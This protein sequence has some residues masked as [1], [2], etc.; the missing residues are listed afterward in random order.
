MVS[1]WWFIAAY[2]CYRE[3]QHK[4][5]SHRMAVFVVDGPCTVAT[6]FD[7]D[8]ERLPRPAIRSL[9]LSWIVEPAC[10]EL[11]KETDGLGGDEV[12]DI[13]EAEDVHGAPTAADTT[14]GT[15]TSEPSES[16]SIPD[17]SV[18]WGKRRAE[19]AGDVSSGQEREKRRDSEHDRR[20]YRID[21]RYRVLRRVRGMWEIMEENL[22]S[23]GF[24]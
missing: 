12:C 8:I 18:R 3:L 10:Q 14:N 13:T 17:S 7:S 1:W 21:E 20:S 22:H 9:D 4:K 23:Y 11:G 6:L 15:M 5:L 24:L 19:D 16:K 2:K